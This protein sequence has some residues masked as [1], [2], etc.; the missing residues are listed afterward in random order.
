M[1]D[2]LSPDA[3]RRTS[4]AVTPVTAVAVG[5]RSSAVTGKEYAAAAM[6]SKAAEEEEMESVFI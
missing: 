4:F 5:K 6:A 1:T 2:C 3:F